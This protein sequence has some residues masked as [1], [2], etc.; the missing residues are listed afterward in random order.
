MKKTNKFFAIAGTLLALAS[1]DG[2][3]TVP[4]FQ[5]EDAFAAF[6]IPAVSVNEDA[7]KVVVP[8]SIASIKP[9]A[10]AVTYKIEE[11][12]AKS[13]V[14]FK[15]TD[16]SA[17]L[18]FNGT[19][20]EMGIE[21]D[22]INIAGEFT[23]DLT[24]KVIL[25]SAGDLDIGANNTCEITIKDLDHPLAEIL[26]DYTVKAESYFN[27]PL[28]WPLVIDKDGKSLTS[29]RIGNIIKMVADQMPYPQSNPAYDISFIA[30]VVFDEDHQIV[31]LSLP[32]GQECAY[33]YGG[34]EPVAL[35]SFDAESESFEDKSGNITL[36][37]SEGKFV[38]KEGWGLFLTVHQQFFDIVNNG[39]V[40]I[41]K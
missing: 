18:N 17:V 35:V 20:R 15:L 13:G 11:V 4:E 23:G 14:N 31:G 10:A 39:A 9:I 16:P 27:G 37:Y 12:T 38:A 3:N 29:V 25:E 34:T 7:G 6:G 28:E 26:G 1:C 22:V 40:W 5:E 30:N 24:F 36:T 19:D 32:V 33:K 41:K 21:I 8:V 2:L